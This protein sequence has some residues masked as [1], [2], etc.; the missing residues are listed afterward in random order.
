MFGSFPRN[1]VGG[2]PGAIDAR[3][4]YV[5]AAIAPPTGDRDWDKSTHNVRKW[6]KCIFIARPR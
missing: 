6:A 4:P 5:E 2:W 3:T 1:G